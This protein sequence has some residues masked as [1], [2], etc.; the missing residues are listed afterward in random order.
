MKLTTR[1]IQVFGARY[2]DSSRK[3]ATDTMKQLLADMQPVANV[4]DLRT[5]GLFLFLLFP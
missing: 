3:L 2:H 1:Q 5:R 4:H